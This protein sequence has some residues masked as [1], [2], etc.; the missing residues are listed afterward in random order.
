MADHGKTS[1][2]KNLPQD[3]QSDEVDQQPATLSPTTLRTL[4][5]STLEKLKD[6]AIQNMGAL[7]FLLDRE[8]TLKRYL[9]THQELL[10]DC[11]VIIEAHGHKRLV[12]KIDTAIKETE[13]T[14]P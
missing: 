9:N 2:P 6:S 11:R 13:A 7:Q 3:I 14:A 10:R 4:S 5:T 12:S 1:K 8:Q